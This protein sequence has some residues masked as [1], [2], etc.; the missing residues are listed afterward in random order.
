[1]SPKAISTREI[2]TSVKTDSKLIV[3]KA[4]S[5][6]VEFQMSGLQPNKIATG[7]YYCKL[8]ASA[9][10]RLRRIVGNWE[11]G[12]QVAAKL[13]FEPP[14]A[15]GSRVEIQ[16]RLQQ[17][18]VDPKRCIG[19]GVCEHECP[20]AGLRAIRVTAENESRAHEHTLLL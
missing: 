4:D 19:C 13:P 1:M 7:D 12:L 9:D 20:I 5:Y 6:Y 3:A 17:P 8:V 2:F 15:P 16:I 18:Y 11:R 10:S 14:P